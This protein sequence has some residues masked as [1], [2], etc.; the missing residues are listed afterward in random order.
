M[1]IKTIDNRKPQVSITVTLTT[2]IAAICPYSHEPQ[3]GSYIS[4][5]YQPQ[6]KLIELHAVEEFIKELG[7]GTEAIDLETVVQLLAIE[8]Q[9]IPV[10]IKAFYKLK[11]NLEMTCRYQSLSIAPMEID[12]LPK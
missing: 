4:I 5:T 7:Q 10:Y 9:D 6:D 11:N 8:C 3:N 1:A 12:D 2:P